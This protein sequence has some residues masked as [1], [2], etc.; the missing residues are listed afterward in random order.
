MKIT[1][2]FAPDDIVVS[3]QLVCRRGHVVYQP[4]P[5]ATEL[6]MIGRHRRHGNL[7]D[8]PDIEREYFTLNSLHTGIVRFLGFTKASSAATLNSMGGYMPA[9]FVV[10]KEDMP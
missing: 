3:I 9:H 10:N 8:I 5:I 7:D 6:F 2:T 1:C 4:G